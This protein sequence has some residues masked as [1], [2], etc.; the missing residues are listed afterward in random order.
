MCKCVC[1]CVCVCV[2]VGLTCFLCDENAT[3]GLT[4]MYMY[5]L[6]DFV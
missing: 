3:Q 6:N 5:T 1:V 2:Y 4:F